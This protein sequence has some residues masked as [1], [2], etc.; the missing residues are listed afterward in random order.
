MPRPPR[1]PLDASISL[2]RLVAV[3]ERQ[4][5]ADDRAHH[6]RAD[7]EDQR[8]R[9]R[10]RRGL[11][12][13]RLLLL[14]LRLAPLGL[15]RFGLLPLRRLRLRLLPRGLSLLLVSRR[16]A[17]ERTVAEASGLGFHHD[18]LDPRRPDRADHRRGR[19]A[20][21]PSSRA[22]SPDAGCGVGLIDVDG[23]GLERVAAGIR[24]AETAVADV[25]DADRADRRDRCAGR[26]ARRPRRRRGQRR[27]RHRRAAATCRRGDRRGD[28]R[29][30]PARRLAHGARLAAARRRASRP[31]AARRVGGGGAADAAGSAPTARRRP[32]SRR[33]AARC[34]SSC[35][36]TTSRSRSPTTCS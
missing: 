24:G 6:Q 30:Q 25:R 16:P 19:P 31:P 3:D 18:D 28:D 11:R 33:S 2:A 35:G 20:S 8:R 10:A 7:P 4:R 34:G 23:D 36:R 26:P 1:R 17:H 15:L 22:S 21:A 13:P 5:A 27:D 12:L 9:G 32:G 29:H 14:L